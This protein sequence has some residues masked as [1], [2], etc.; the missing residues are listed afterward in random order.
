MAQHTMG[1]NQ[2]WKSTLIYIYLLVI[3]ARYLQVIWYEIDLHFCQLNQK[4]T[5]DCLGNCTWIAQ[6]LFIYGWHLWTLHFPAFFSIVYIVTFLTFLFLLLKAQVIKSKHKCGIHEYENGLCIMSHGELI[7]TCKM[8][9]PG[10]FSRF[11]QPVHF[12][13]L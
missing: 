4:M 7:Y 12:S 8:I 5:G 1:W 6:Q 9:Q 11:S 2:I 3:F 13:R 10:I